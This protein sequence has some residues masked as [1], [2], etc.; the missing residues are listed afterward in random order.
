[1]LWGVGGS[2]GTGFFFGIEL[3]RVLLGGGCMGMQGAALARYR[4]RVAGEDGTAL[5]RELDD[6]K[7]HGYRLSAP[8]LKRVPNAYGQDHPHGTLLRHKS[9][10]SWKDIEKPPTDLRAVLIE[11]FTALKPILAW[12]DD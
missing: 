9:L 1:M 8:E 11:G 4:D 7:S 3:D 10:T 5:A 12:L 2:K 6:L